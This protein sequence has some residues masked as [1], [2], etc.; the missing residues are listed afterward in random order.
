MNRDNHMTRVLFV[1]SPFGDIKLLIPRRVTEDNVEHALKSF[2]ISC[3][4]A[5]WFRCINM[6][7]RFQRSTT[8]F[9]NGLIKTD[10]PDMLLDEFC[11]NPRIF[12]NACQVSVL[13]RYNFMKCCRYLENW[14]ISQ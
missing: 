9:Y 14:C 11:N 5:V 1:Y 13:M 8:V 7:S 10:H 4:R 6:Q 2:T 12:G 3:S